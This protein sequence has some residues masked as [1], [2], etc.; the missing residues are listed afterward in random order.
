MGL[1]NRLVPP[2]RALASAIALAADLARFPQLC[3]RNDRLSSYA[4]WSRSLDDAL[5]EEA[6]L[7]LAVMQSGEATA[8]AQR[9]VS[10]RGRHGAMDDV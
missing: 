6:R 9:F 2:G 1:A 7:G 5:R 3:L 4:Q 10:G 8:G